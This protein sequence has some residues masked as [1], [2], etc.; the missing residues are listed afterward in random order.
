LGYVF[1]ASHCRYERK[2]LK[3]R[4]WEEHQAAK[5]EAELKKLQVN[6]NKKN[7]TLFFAN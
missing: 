5:A 6:K 3:I 7:S 2:E 4:A 1:L